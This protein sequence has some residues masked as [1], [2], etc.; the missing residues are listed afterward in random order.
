MDPAKKEPEPVN[1]PTPDDEPSV[2]Q[3]P[4]PDTSSQSARGRGGR[5]RSR[6]RGRRVVPRQVTRR[7]PPAGQTVHVI[8]DT[9]SPRGG[10]GR[11]GRG[12]EGGGRGRGRGQEG[13][14]RGRG[15]AREVL[16]HSPNAVGLGQIAPPRQSSRAPS[17][18]NSA[19]SSR[20]SSAIS[21]G[22]ASSTFSVGR[23]PASSAGS[24]EAMSYGTTSLPT[25]SAFSA[26]ADPEPPLAGR[27]GAAGRGKAAAKKDT[28]DIT[29][30]EHVEVGEDSDDD[31]PDD[32]FDLRN[33]DIA[34][35]AGHLTEDGVL[36]PVSLPGLR[37]LPVKFDAFTGDED[38][39]LAGSKIKQE[40]DDVPLAKSEPMEI[41]SIE[42]VE[43]TFGSLRASMFPT[44]SVGYCILSSPST[45]SFFQLPGLLPLTETAE[46]RSKKQKEKK[47]EKLS[48]VA[49]AVAASE[50]LRSLGV[51]LRH[52][53]Q[54]GETPN[55]GK[56][57]FYKSGRVK[58]VF[59]NG[60]SCDVEMGIA[61]QVCQQAVLINSKEK[62]C[63][64]L[65]NTVTTRY[66]A[67]PS[68]EG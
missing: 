30:D 47:G 40:P 45:L 1:P 5:G 60:G 36:L 63:E 42:P 13:G 8:A 49:E 25:D 37:S 12:K 64:E 3:P 20:R 6:S 48:S 44:D 58:M 26:S 23:N 33:R 27:A 19:V 29:F 21:S 46:Y 43:P 15:G 51:D 4:N 52:I 55:V 32:V 57:R 2:P 41:D 62:T 68:L 16:T 9:S 66:M 50:R 65:Q 56:L 54:P 22:A 18:N 17:G 67:V 24:D 34:P 35:Y 59:D 14:G 38:V 10:R 11:G 53:G 39:A 31:M 61:P 7:K 28:N